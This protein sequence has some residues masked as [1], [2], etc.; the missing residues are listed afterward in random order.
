MLSGLIR[1]L[2]AWWRCQRFDAHVSAAPSGDAIR[3]WSEFAG[4]R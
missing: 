2:R 1:T 3:R 4:Q